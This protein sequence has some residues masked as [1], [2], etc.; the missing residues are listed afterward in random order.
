MVSLKPLRLSDF[1]T[2]IYK[3]LLIVEH[4]QAFLSLKNINIHFLQINR[5]G[6]QLTNQL[7]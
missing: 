4:L 2:I 3:T 7:W 6:T 5:K 1:L